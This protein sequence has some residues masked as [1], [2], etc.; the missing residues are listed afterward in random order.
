[1][2]PGMRCLKTILDTFCLLGVIGTLLTNLTP[3]T[4]VSFP[5][6]YDPLKAETENTDF[7]S[8]RKRFLEK[9]IFPGEFHQS[10][11]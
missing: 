7:H 6:N 2:S 10:T 1:M 11:E 5:F 3:L 9:K 4:P 8:F